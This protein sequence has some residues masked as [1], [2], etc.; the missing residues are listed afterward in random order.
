[1]VRCPEA[2]VCAVG[3]VQKPNIGPHLE[4]AGRH[5][6]GVIKVLLAMPSSAN[7]REMFI[8]SR[9][10]LIS[11]LTELHSVSPKQSEPWEPLRQSERSDGCRVAPGISSFRIWRSETRHVLLE[12][13]SEPT[14]VSEK[15]KSHS[16]GPELFLFSGGAIRATL[17]GN[18]RQFSRLSSAALPRNPMETAIT[19]SP[20]QIAY[21]LQVG[22]ETVGR[23]PCRGSPQTVSELSGELTKYLEDHRKQFCSAAM[24]TENQGLL[25]DCC[26]KCTERRPISRTTP[27]G[28][29]V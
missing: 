29:S 15:T 19:E 18:G 14:I 26:A 2:N 21:T 5:R 9:S 3:S 28:T 11:R 1:L 24:W 17:E 4:T 22:R 25:F 10:I 12:E 20:V 27:G 23:A 7:S 8:S 6:G 16:S 13:Y